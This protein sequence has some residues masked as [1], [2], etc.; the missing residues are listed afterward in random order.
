M[1]LINADALIAEMHNIILEDG[2]D[3]RIFYDVIERQPTI[4]EASTVQPEIVRCKDCKY[5]GYN[6]CF[7]GFGR[8][9]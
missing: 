6:E 1:R 9:I 4:E 8:S 7:H 5:Y 3:R 2:E